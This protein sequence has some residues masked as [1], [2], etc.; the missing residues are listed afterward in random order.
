MPKSFASRKGFTLI[1]LL[2]VIA[3]IAILIGLLLP[4]VQKVRSAAAR[5]VSQN[6]LKQLGLAMHS[7]HD[8]NQ[9]LPPMYGNYSTN[10]EPASLFYHMLPYLEQSNVHAMGPDL[11]RSQKIKTFLAPA[12]VTAGDGLV[13]I[14]ESYTGAPTA[15]GVGSWI[16][17]G[18]TCNPYLGTTFNPANTT[19]GLSSYG[20]NW[21]FFGD[22]PVAFNKASDGL[23]KTTFFAEKYAKTYRPAGNPRWGA[24]LWGYGTAAPAWDYRNIGISPAEHNYASGLWA[25]FGFVNL[26]G[27]SSVWDGDPTELWKCA[28]HKK[29]EFNPPVN[30][31]HPLKCQAYGQT[32]MVCMGDGSVLAINSSITDVNF[33]TANTPDRGDISSDSQLP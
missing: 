6:N 7:L 24:S 17:T 14:A 10:A 32:I 33:L 31:S 21:Q 3:I 26:A 23:S 11:A 8:A 13:Q 15:F 4:A 25:R 1:E 18:N 12:D 19:W 20:A 9:K 30:N 2:V 22:T 16:T 27:A 29:P 28:C 5:T